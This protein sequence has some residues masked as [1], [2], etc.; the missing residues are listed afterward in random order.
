MVFDSQRFEMH[1]RESSSNDIPVMAIHH[2][3]MFEEI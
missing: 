3:K 1:I 2:R